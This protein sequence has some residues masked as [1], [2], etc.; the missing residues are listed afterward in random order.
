[1][2]LVAAIEAFIKLENNYRDMRQT[3][4]L[5]FLRQ[6]GPYN[7]KNIIKKCNDK[8]YLISI[9]DKNTIIG[10]HVLRLLDQG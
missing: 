1:M 10:A 4:G 5:E 3:V 8:K 6:Q 7:A 9:V 2:D